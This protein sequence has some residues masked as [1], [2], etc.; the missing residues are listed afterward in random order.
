MSIKMTIHGIEVE[1]E[2][3]EEAKALLGL[4]G[5]GGPQAQEPPKER[6]RMQYPAM[7][8]EAPVEEPT[9]PKTYRG[10][11]KSKRAP[12]RTIGFEGAEKIRSLAAQGLNCNQ[13][14]KALD[15]NPTSVKNVL[16]GKTWN[17]ET[18]FAYEQK[19]K[20]L[21]KGWK[22][23]SPKPQ[24]SP[25]KPTLVPVQTTVTPTDKNKENLREI[26]ELLRM[27]ESPNEVCRAYKISPIVLWTV[28]H[29]WYQENAK[30]GKITNLQVLNQLSRTNE[31]MTLWFAQNA[32]SPSNAMKQN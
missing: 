20:A 5:G 16:E 22:Q 24:A 15:Y 30:V 4:G 26:I 8:N 27:N 12:A 11:D 2:S 9:E 6:V 25:S 32:S 21:S 18:K 10:K 23:L 17:E 1:V 28:W 3:V 29:D 31:S 13:I 14:A 19:G 7:P